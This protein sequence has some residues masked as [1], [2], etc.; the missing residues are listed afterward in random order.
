M[1]LAVI[2][3]PL[4]LFAGCKPADAPPAAT[5]K[6][7]TQILQNFEMQDIQLGQ[8][9]MT[10]RAR[11]GRVFDAD[12]MA[13]LDHPEV[14]FFKTGE[15][16]SHMSSPA[17]R[18]HMQTHVID[19]WGGVKVVTPDSSTLTTE[20]LQYDPKV[21]KIFS[22]SHV[23]LEKPDSVTEGES[24]EADPDLKR[25]KISRQTVRFKRSVKGNNL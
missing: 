13:E 21:R 18:I 20:R 2:L 7:P 22:K 12:Q 19:A 5:G 8:K 23:K 17:G 11:E 15:P 9:S 24:L 16:S 1:R 14:T 6:T 10:L 25:V 3:A 4:L